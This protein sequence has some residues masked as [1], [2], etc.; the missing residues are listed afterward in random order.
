MQE[1][2]NIEEFEEFE[3]LEELEESTLVVEFITSIII[4]TIPKHPEVLGKNLF[5]LGAS[6]LAGSAFYSEPSITLQGLGTTFCFLGLAIPRF[7]APTALPL[8]PDNE[9][10]APRPTIRTHF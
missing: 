7:L 2:P 4:E 8:G 10:I 6:L 5:G 3:E 1:N 9:P